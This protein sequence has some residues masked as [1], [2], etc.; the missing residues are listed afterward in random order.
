MK[1]GA[2][3]PDLPGGAGDVT[4]ARLDKL[5]NSSGSHSTSDIRRTMQ[6]T[7]Q[8]QLVDPYSFLSPHME[9]IPTRF[10]E[11]HERVD[12]TCVMHKSLWTLFASGALRVCLAC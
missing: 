8:V 6:R 5:R 7:M 9:P 1:P 12:L 10:L 3:Q 11:V 4:I 2:A